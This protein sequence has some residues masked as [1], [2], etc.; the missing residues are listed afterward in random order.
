MQFINDIEKLSTRLSFELNA[1]TFCVSQNQRENISDLTERIF[2]LFSENFDI[3][4]VF[5]YESI[6]DSD[7]DCF[8]YRSEESESESLILVLSSSLLEESQDALKVVVVES[9]CFAV[10]FG[11]EEDVNILELARR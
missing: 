5:V 7:C 2:P 3:S 6:N 11:V 1:K 8:L 9:L 4:G 10:S